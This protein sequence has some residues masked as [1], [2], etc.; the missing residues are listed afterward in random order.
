MFYVPLANKHKDIKEARLTSAL[1]VQPKWVKAIASING[2]SKIWERR[3]VRG[4]DLIKM[5][6]LQP[7]VIN[8]LLEKHQEVPMPGRSRNDE[9]SLEKFE[10][11]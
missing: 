1:A 7:L 2:W 6:F 3:D 8:K 9:V 11:A 4:L 5:Y 10:L